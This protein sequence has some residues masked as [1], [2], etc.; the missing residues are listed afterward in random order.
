[1]TKNDHSQPEMDTDDLLLQHALRSEQAQGLHVDV[2]EELEKVHSTIEQLK[3]AAPAASEKMRGK[4]SYVL[5]GFAT[6]IA[7]TL[8]V[9]LGIKVLMKSEVQ[10]APVVVY[11]ADENLSDQVTLQ[12]G[13]HSVEVVAE[14]ELDL[15]KLADDQDSEQLQILTT[16][17]QK[18]FTL[19]LHD[20]TKVTLNHDSQLV[21][22]NRFG[23][24]DRA[25]QL[26]GEAF[27]EV[28][29]DAKHPFLVQTQQF[30]TQ[31]LGTSFNVRNYSSDASHVTLLEG[32]VKVT[33][34]GEEVTLKPSEDVMLSPG[35][36]MAV[37]EVDTDIFTAWTQGEFYYDNISLL[38]V[39]R[40]I[41][42]WYNIDV[43]FNSR[44][45]MNTYVHFQ[46]CRTDGIEETVSVLNMLGKAKFSL[47]S[48]KLYID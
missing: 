9:L 36:K 17:A 12:R 2:E 42:R 25:V 22:P 47:K 7:A 10:E 13:H 28:A 43:I 1:M 27:F 37:T 19:T 8:V 31:V 4:M 39:A 45:S 38:D 48:G 11:L 5:L 23:A 44:Q 15:T 16:P 20:G 46:A 21:F 18:S 40:Q 32:S 6:G 41:G 34:E 35:G 26:R 30:V 24:G 3:Q 14:Q 29:K 33:S